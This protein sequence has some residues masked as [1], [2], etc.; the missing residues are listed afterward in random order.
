[1]NFR[2]SFIGITITT[3]ILFNCIKTE[4]QSKKFISR[5]D[6]NYQP[7][8]SYYYN[9]YWEDFYDSEIADVE[10]DITNYDT[11]L[12][13]AAVFFATNKYRASKRKKILKYFLITMIQIKYL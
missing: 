4:A 7:D 8:T 5:L 9:F 6:T 1:M 2:K 13:N 11:S 12:L 3:I 10:F